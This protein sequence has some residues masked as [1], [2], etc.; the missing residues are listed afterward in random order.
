MNWQP[1]CELRWVEQTVEIP[2]GNECVRVVQEKVL[3]QKWV[4]DGPRNSYGEM[5][6]TGDEWRDVPVEKE[7]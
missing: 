4:G 7:A 6:N 1:T 5:F 3:Q 2:V